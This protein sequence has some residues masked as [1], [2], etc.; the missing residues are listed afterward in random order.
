MSVS[1]AACHSPEYLPIKMM[2]HVD[3]HLPATARQKARRVSCEAV[4]VG[5]EQT[6]ENDWRVALY[7]LGLAGDD[8]EVV[9]RFVVETLEAGR[10][11]QAAMVACPSQ[12]TAAS[13]DSSPC[14]RSVPK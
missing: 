1:G 6:G 7:F 12:S 2:V 5:Q 11:G 3:L 14:V 10:E 13:T 4:V 8:H 9:K